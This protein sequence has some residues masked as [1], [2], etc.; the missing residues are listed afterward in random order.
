[1][2]G[3]ISLWILVLLGLYSWGQEPVPLKLFQLKPERTIGNFL[4]L[5]SLEQAKPRENYHLILS[6]NKL[7]AV[8]DGDGQVF[9]PENNSWKRID[10]TR[11]EGYHYGAFLFDCNGSLMKYGGYGFWRSHGMFVRFNEYNGDWQIQPSDRD[12]PF[13]G[14]LAYFNKKSNTLYSFGNYFYNQST[15][16]EK[17]FI[18]SLFRIDLLKMK[19]ENLGHLNERLINQYHLQHRLS[20]LSSSNGCLILPISSDSTAIFFNFEDLTYQVFNANCN[21]RLFSFL[22]E[23]PQ[24]QRLYSDAYGL[25]ILNCDSIRN[26]DS[27]PWSQALNN[28]AYLGK[29]IETKP[30]LSTIQYA[31]LACVVLSVIILL[32][33]L[34]SKKRSNKTE[35]TN[36]EEDPCL[37]SDGLDLSI[38]NTLVFKGAMYPIDSFDYQVIRKFSIQDAT[39]LDLN[40]WLGLENKQLENQK[41][42]RAEWIKR[43]NVFFNS[44]GFKEEAFNRE[45]QESDKRMFVYKMNT[46]LKPKEDTP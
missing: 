20:T 29:I 3:V 12:L 32:V 26:I 36:S 9:T 34:L 13:G 40:E 35:N 33:Y 27:I 19:W 46:K 45:R 38:S 23:L 31:L 30:G 39:T 2:K 1:M 17:I 15:S 28:P 16:S 37:G 44:I 4:P 25:K 24:N 6:H 10:K 43:M 22:I 5:D 11:L 18:D 41:K 8:G 7:Y 42:Q 21:P 14:E